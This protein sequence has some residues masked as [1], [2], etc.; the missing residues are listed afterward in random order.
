[1]VPDIKKADLSGQSDMRFIGKK[2]YGYWYWGE[3]LQANRAMVYKIFTGI[4]DVNP[5]EATKA[6]RVTRTTADPLNVNGKNCVAA[7]CWPGHLFF[8]QKEN[9]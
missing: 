9:L 5:S 3:A 2:P 6:E 8:V 4:E 1:M 7:P